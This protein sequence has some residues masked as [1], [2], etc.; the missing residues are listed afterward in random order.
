MTIMLIVLLIMC[1][2]QDQLRS[3]EE[4]MNQTELDLQDHRQYPPEKGSKSSTIQHFVEKENYLLF[5]VCTVIFFICIVIFAL[6][7]YAHFKKNI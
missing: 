4:Q 1:F 3:L 6:P 2:Q 7:V 5:E